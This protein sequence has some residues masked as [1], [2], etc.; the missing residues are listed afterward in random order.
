ML[1]HSHTNTQHSVPAHCVHALHDT[2]TSDDFAHTAETD[3]TQRN[4]VKGME[5]GDI[6]EKCYVRTRKLTIAGRH[7]GTTAK[8]DSVFNLVYDDS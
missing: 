6:G 4:V 1:R 8:P 2:H 5:R 7:C 3:L